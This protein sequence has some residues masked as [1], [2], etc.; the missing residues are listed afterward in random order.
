MQPVANVALRQFVVQF[1]GFAQGQLAQRKE[2][3]GAASQILIGAGRKTRDRQLLRARQRRM[4]GLHRDLALG[5][6]VGLRQGQCIH[7]RQAGLRL[8]LQQQQRAGQQAFATG[9]AA[10]PE[11]VDVL[12][13][14]RLLPG[15]QLAGTQCV[16]VRQAQR[17]A[18][19]GGPGA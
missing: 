15:S 5:T 9:I 8:Q 12:G 7:R 6:R 1:A 2:S 18:L 10:P 13:A 3:V 4:T 11:Q 19:G 17:G 16:A 14:Q